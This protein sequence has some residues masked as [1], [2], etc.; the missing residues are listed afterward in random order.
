MHKIPKTIHQIW[1]QGEE[2]IPSNYRYYASSWRHYN[3]DY[4][5]LLWVKEDI[6]ELISKIYPHYYNF[7][8]SLPSMIQKI[9]FAKYCI[10]YAYGGVY[11]D[12]DSECLKPID[13]LFSRSKKKLFVVSLDVDIFEQFASNYY[14][15]L[16]NNGWFASTQKNA[17]WKLVMKHISKQSMER[18]W[19]ETNIGYIFRTTGPKAFSQVVNNFSEKKVIDNNLIDPIKWTDYISPA[20]IDYS[21]YS[22]SYS[23]H[24][25]G[26][27]SI[28]GNSWQS[29][30]EIML[31]MLLHYFKKYWKLSAVVIVLLILDHTNSIL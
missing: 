18:H 29:N 13:S 14:E 10:M 28:N 20:H 2:H 3:K 11:V 23:I 17:L 16:Y 6:S 12:M 25:Y 15:T 8:E 5:Y 9:D 7:Y 30:S 19:Y 1:Y 31:G 26:S 4:E 27:K 22:D 21:K 24:H